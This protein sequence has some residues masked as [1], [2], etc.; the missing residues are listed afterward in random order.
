MSKEPVIRE[1]C[2]TYAGYRAHRRYSETLCQPCRDAMNAYRR[3]HIR[4]NPDFNA[5]HRKAYREAHPELTRLAS[6]HDKIIKKLMP[7][8][9]ER[10]GT[11]CYICNEPIDMEAPRHTR[12]TVGWDKG[13]NID[14]VVPI[15]KGGEA[16]IDNLKPAHVRCNIQKRDGTFLV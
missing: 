1:K 13:L 10:W 12:G 5:R 14:H 3:E 9:L 8:I 11:D 2:G 7:E 16:T 6:E 4:K 15:S